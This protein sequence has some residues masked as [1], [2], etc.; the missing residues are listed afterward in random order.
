M[1]GYVLTRKVKADQTEEQFAVIIV[2]LTGEANRRFGQGGWRNCLCYIIPTIW[3]SPRC[4]TRIK[5]AKSKSTGFAGP[6]PAPDSKPN[7]RLPTDLYSF[8][9]SKGKK[10]MEQKTR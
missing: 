4:W 5:M 8:G 6:S 2:I 3:N 10:H 9:K 1:D 7:P